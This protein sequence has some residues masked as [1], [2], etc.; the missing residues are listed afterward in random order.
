[1]VPYDSLAP[2]TSAQPCP[3]CGELLHWSEQEHPPTAHFD[4]RTGRVCSV[5][6]MRFCIACG[7]REIGQVS[8]NRDPIWREQKEGGEHDA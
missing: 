5:T 3:R 1:M 4:T 2:F 7:Y 8:V 6:L